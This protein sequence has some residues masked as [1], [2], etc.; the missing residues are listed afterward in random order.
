MSLV[1]YSPRNYALNNF[2]RYFDSLFNWDIPSYSRNSRVTNYWE[3]SGDKATLPLEIPGFKKDEISVKLVNR[4]V[5]VFGKKDSRDFNYRYSLPR[6]S[7][8]NTLTASLEDGI[9]TIGVELNTPEELEI[10]VR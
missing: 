4:V 1:R 9:L 8:P 3:I 7:N 10:E 5:S 6:N 2:D